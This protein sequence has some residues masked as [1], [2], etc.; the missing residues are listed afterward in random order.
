MTGTVRVRAATPADVPALVA[1]VHAAFASRP[2]LDPPSTQ[3]LETE[4]SVGVVV[5]ATGG[6]VAEADG[7][8]IGAVLL[9]DHGDRLGLHRVSVHPDHQ[10]RGVVGLLARAAEDV[11]RD[12]GCSGIEVGARVELPQTVEL[13]LHHGYALVDRAGPHLT[14]AKE[15]PFALAVPEADDARAL[16]HRLAPLLRA[17]DLLILTGD[18]GAGK[19]TFTQGLGQ[20]LGVRG[21]VT[22]PTFILARAHPSLG[23]GPG[24]VHVDAYRLGGVE[25][26]DDLDLDSALA[27]SVAVV[28]WGEGLAESLAEDRLEITLRRRR[29][30]ERSGG[31]DDT[32]PREVEVRPV[33]ARWVGA[34]LREALSG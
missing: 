27:T 4:E 7:E 6:L 22:S 8:V 18:L 13:W 26:L 19:T 23:D 17:G 12:R 30:D 9:G 20:G 2:V 33:G 24:L 1:V 34:G 28:E 5:A 29:G 31:I 10:G 15:L 25:E 32:D 14:M 16:G 21:Q 11:A 3:L